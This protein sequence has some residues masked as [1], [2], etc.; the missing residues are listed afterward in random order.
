MRV[1]DRQNGPSCLP[2][3]IGWLRAWLKSVWR[4]ENLENYETYLAL[5]ERAVKEEI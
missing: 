2:E 3:N 1:Q 4:R 5:A